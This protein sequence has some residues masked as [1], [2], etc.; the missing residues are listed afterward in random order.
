MFAPPITLIGAHKL[1]P[2]LD[3]YSKRQKRLRGEN[4]D[5][6]QFENMPIAFRNQVIHILRDAF[7]ETDLY[8]SDA[9]AAYQAIHDALCREYGLFY[10]SE[11]ARV[12]NYQLALFNFFQE[13][14]DIEKVLDVIELSFKVISNLTYPYKQKAA[15]RTGYGEAVEELNA[16]FLEHGIG[17]QLEADQIVRAD[18]KYIHNEVVKPALAVLS[19]TIYKGANEEFLKA[20][21]HYRHGRIKE[22]LNECL[23]SFESTLK[24]ICAKHGWQSSESD[25]AKKLIATCFDNKLIPPYL[26]TQFSTI[27]SVLESGVPTVRNKLSGHGQGSQQTEV[28]RYM[29]EYALHLTATSILFLANADRALK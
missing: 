5:V 22:C 29:A 7:G 6:F 27:R 26:E 14:D 20:H 18:S 10:L 4:P 11:S 9:M 21:E 19:E 24:A 12:G 23:K 1:M 16:R 2:I 13:S 25:T 3:I 15:V 28:P 17:F 8:G